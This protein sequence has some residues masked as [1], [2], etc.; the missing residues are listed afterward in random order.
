MANVARPVLRW[1]ISRSRGGLL[2]T[3]G[4]GDATLTVM[5]DNE[6]ELTVGSGPV[7]IAL[8]GAVSKEVRTISTSAATTF[9]VG[10]VGPAKWPRLTEGLQADAP[11]I[12]SSDWDHWSDSDADSE[13]EGDGEGEVRTFDI[14]DRGVEIEHTMGEFDLGDDG[15]EP[16]CE[17]HPVGETVVEETG[18]EVM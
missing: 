11:V 2:L 5:G 18:N 13:P 7:R 1:S 9:L 17:C 10:I 12:I 15:C 6:V 8:F 3:V 16:G 4:S 14:A